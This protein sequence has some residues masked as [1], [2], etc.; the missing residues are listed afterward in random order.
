MIHSG[1]QSPEGLCPVLSP[2]VIQCWLAKQVIT[3]LS[4]SLSCIS[5]SNFHSFGKLHFDWRQL[6]GVGDDNVGFVF[7]VYSSGGSEG[8]SVNKIIIDKNYN[9]TASRYY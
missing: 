8:H 2:A 1:V 9:I 6:S 7:S 5:K 3:S 4:L